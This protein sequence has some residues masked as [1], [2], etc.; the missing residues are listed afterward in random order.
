MNKNIKKRILTITLLLFPFI[1]ISYGMENRG[2]K[3]VREDDTETGRPTKKQKINN[4]KTTNIIDLPEFVRKHIF[5]Y[6]ADEPKSLMNINATCKDFHNDISPLIEFRSKDLKMWQTLLENLNTTQDNY[7]KN[8]KLI[9]SLFEKICKL[10]YNSTLNVIIPKLSS[11]FMDNLDNCIL[12]FNMEKDINLILNAYSSI[13]NNNIRAQFTKI[14]FLNCFNYHNSYLIE[15]TE[16]LNLLIKDIDFNAPIDI[17]IILPNVLH[18]IS[19]LTLAFISEYINTK[20]LKLIMANKKYN[21]NYASYLT[22]RFL[23]YETP[24]IITC[25]N[26]LVKLETKKEIISFLLKNGADINY[27]TKNGR[28]AFSQTL[29]CEELCI[30]EKKQLLKF[31]E[32]N[33]AVVEKKQLSEKIYADKKLTKDEKQEISKILSNI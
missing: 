16:T 4:P 3:R 18:S 6:L 7:K 1:S 12:F 20:F 28:T 33:G 19:L 31:L 26:F 17:S 23:E 25:S 13:K 21:F 24:L 2:I 27:T 22:G 10:N 9:T 29:F 11:L 14:V 15:N 32:K 5:S 8:F 30:G